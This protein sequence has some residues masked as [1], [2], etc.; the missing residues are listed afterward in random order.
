MARFNVGKAYGGD[1]RTR[2]SPIRFCIMHFI[3]YYRIYKE[4]KDLSLEAGCLVGGLR[5]HEERDVLRYLVR[6]E[7]LDNCKVR[8]CR[9]GKIISL[10]KQ[11]QSM[12]DTPGL[13]SGGHDYYIHKLERRYRIMT[14]IMANYREVQ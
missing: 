10:R 12:L 4:Q 9:L 13:H 6:N 14:E 5:Y 11:F 1:I 2:D 8:Q 3:P 7:G